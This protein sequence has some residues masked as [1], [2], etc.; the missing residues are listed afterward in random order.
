MHWFP[1]DWASLIADILTLLSVAGTAFLTVTA[2]QVRRQ[3]QRAILLPTF[4]NKLSSHCD[5]LTDLLD[6]YTNSINEISSELGKIE[7]N[8]HSLSK[9]LRRTEMKP[10]NAALSSL[11]AYRLSA[12][13]SNL[14]IVYA[15]ITRLLVEIQNLTEGLRWQ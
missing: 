2:V 10:V 5:Q 7:G 15:D 8:L 12:T 9:Y 6:A 3:F 13:E 14:R 1:S 4:T 11:A